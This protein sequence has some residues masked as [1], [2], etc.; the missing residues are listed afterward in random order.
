M[1]QR[2]QL[3]I[4]QKSVDDIKKTFYRAQDA[5]ESEKNTELSSVDGGDG[6]DYIVSM[7]TKLANDA[8]TLALASKLGG[9]KLGIAQAKL[10]ET[11]ESV[12][13]TFLNMKKE[14]H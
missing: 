10:T 14:V 5:L 11:D 9:D 13:Q 3:K 7:I 12:A 4:D 2:R 6:T 8:C 1:G